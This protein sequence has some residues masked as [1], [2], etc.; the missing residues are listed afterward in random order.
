MYVLSANGV[1]EG[2]KKCEVYSCIPGFISKYKGHLL[3]SESNYQKYHVKRRIENV[4]KAC[5]IPGAVG[6]SKL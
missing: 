5:P 1:C 2:C 3:I 4:I 6:I